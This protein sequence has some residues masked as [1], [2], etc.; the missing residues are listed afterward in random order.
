MPQTDSIIVTGKV[1]G[2]FF[3][4]YTREMA[5]ELGLTGWV[6]NL[7]DGSV[8]ILASG[9]PAQ[10]QALAAWCR[11]G[12]PKSRVDTV[13]VTTEAYQSFTAFSIVR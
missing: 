9:E 4:R 3:R 8:S 7:T 12:P 6:K 13:I 10:L 11:K 2:V 1:Q 5:I